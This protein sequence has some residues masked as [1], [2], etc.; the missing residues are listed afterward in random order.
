MRPIELR[1][2]AIVN[3]QCLR[4][5]PGLRDAFSLDLD[6]YPLIDTSHTPHK[7]G[8]LLC[9]RVPILLLHAMHP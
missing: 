1:S 9:M 6:R 4:N 2:K 7:F 3:A 5:G 8:Q